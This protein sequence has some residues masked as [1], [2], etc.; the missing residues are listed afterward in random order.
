MRAKTPPPPL[1]SKTTPPPLPSQASR[2]PPMV[3]TPPQG[4]LR[5]RVSVKTSVLD[6]TLLVVRRLE[7][8]KALPNGT[9]EGWLETT[10][11]TN[12]DTAQVPHMNGKSV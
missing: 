3:T 11:S 7:E 1:P 4:R 10:E 5:I 6:P 2:P 12:V 9:S 8:G